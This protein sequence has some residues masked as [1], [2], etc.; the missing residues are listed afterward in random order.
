Q[1]ALDQTIASFELLVVDDGSSDGTKAIAERVA[2]RD[3]RI[4][5]WSRPNGGACRARNEALRRARGRFVAFLDSDDG[6]MPEYL[7]QQ[8]AVLEQSPHVSVVTANAINVG[9]PLDGQPYWD[10]ASGV[11]PI[12][13]LDM[14]ER[15]DSVCIMSVFHRAVYDSIGGF[16]ETF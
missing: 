15:E 5:V 10:A 13:L 11:R 12:A 1:S 9:G 8:I 14:I 3:A 4:T 7:E 2:E 16:D 6:W